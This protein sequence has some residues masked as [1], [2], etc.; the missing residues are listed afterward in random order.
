MGARHLLQC[1]LVSS[2]VGTPS[3]HT[4]LRFQG[5]C[6][7]WLRSL[8][9]TLLHTCSKQS[10]WG[11][12]ACLHVGTSCL[13]REGACA[14][15]WHELDPSV[16][17][18]R[19]LRLI[20]LERKAQRSRCRLCSSMGGRAAAGVA[21]EKKVRRRYHTTTFAFPAFRT[22][23]AALL[24]LGRVTRIEYLFGGTCA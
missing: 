17:C 15:S 24:W 4:T 23:H 8:G 3:P 9:E 21:V 11:K 5:R 10:L 14:C 6:L 16:S 20:A 12:L 22:P 19:R 13:S 2:C 18:V 1:S 7:L